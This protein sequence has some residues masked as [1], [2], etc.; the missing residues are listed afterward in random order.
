MII[1]F[2]N[3]DFMNMKELFITQ[4]LYLGIIFIYLFLYSSLGIYFDK[5]S[6][7]RSLKK[8]NNLYEN[9]VKKPEMELIISTLGEIPIFIKHRNLITIYMMEVIYTH[10]RDTMD[11]LTEDVLKKK[12][13]HKNLQDT[14]QNLVNIYDPNLSFYMRWIDRGYKSFLYTYMKEL[15]NYETPDEYISMESFFKGIHQI[16][17]IN[18]LQ[19]QKN[20]ENILSDLQNISFIQ[21]DIYQNILIWKELIQL[22]HLLATLDETKY[23]SYRNL[24]YGTSGGESINLRYLQKQIQYIDKLF[25]F[26]ITEEL[27]KPENSER[28]KLISSIK[29]YQ[30]YSTQFWIT[31]FNLAASTNGIHNKGTQNT[32]IMKLIDKC[33]SMINTNINHSIYQISEEIMK[34]DSYKVTISMNDKKKKI[35]L[36]IYNSSKKILQKED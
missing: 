21:K 29:L 13:I 27:L 3:I 11:N 17:E 31:H 2:M 19:I 7:M 16:I 33:T 25:D 5:C 4:S 23:Q 30:Y 14:Y 20:H 34:D 36:S 12:Y 10:I 32:P 8:T 1:D 26:D 24:I 15:I 22:L 9:W 28:K 6:A 18:L 35:G